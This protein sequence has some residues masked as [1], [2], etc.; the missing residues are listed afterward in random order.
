[1]T[2]EPTLAVDTNILV[3]AEALGEIANFKTLAAL[4]MLRPLIIAQRLFVPAQVLGEL[5]GVLERKQRRTRAAAVAT[6]RQW[7][8]YG[9]VA[10]SDAAVMEAA[11]VL[12]ADHGLTIWDAIVV[13]AAAEAGCAVLLTED[14]HDGFVWRGCTVADPFATVRHPLLASLLP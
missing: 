9:R 1:M 10:P 11:F 2:I 13:S 12:A 8:L 3:Y 5:A 7:S 6:A 4:D 14:L